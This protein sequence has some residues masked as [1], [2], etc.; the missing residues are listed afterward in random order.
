MIINDPLSR[1]AIAWAVHQ[2]IVEHD[3][4]RS[5]V[6]LCEWYATAGAEVLYLLTGWRFE[7]V[8]G[9]SWSTSGGAPVTHAS[10]LP[11]DARPGWA[12]L[13]REE[14]P[15]AAHVWV[16]GGIDHV[17]DF[18]IRPAI[19]ENKDALRGHVF[20][21]NQSDTQR[22][23]QKYS[24]LPHLVAA[25]TRRATELAAPSV[26]ARANGETGHVLS[27]IAGRW[28]EVADELGI[29]RKR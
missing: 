5:G 25:I 18:S 9:Y 10:G 14:P 29:L 17:V 19:W 24:G 23:Q 15:P 27:R 28:A 7:A 22:L 16:E 21:P 8:A 26:L 13:V 2:A 20:K 11:L 6:W 1:R 3:S 12:N 4:C